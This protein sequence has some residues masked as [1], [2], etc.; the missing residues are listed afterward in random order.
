MHAA[1]Y[2]HSIEACCLTSG[3]WSLIAIVV[4]FPVRHGT[5]GDD[6]AMHGQVNVT[7][8]VSRACLGVLASLMDGWERQQGSSNALLRTAASSIDGGP[9]RAGHCRSDSVPVGRLHATYQ[10]AKPGTLVTR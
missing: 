9:Q 5:E 4:P 7:L 6:R 8:V 2:Q 10:P 1:A 3:T